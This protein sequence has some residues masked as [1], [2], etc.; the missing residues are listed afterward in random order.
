MCHKV[1]TLSQ[2]HDVSKWGGLCDTVKKTLWHCQNG[3]M[4]VSQRSLTLLFDVISG[5]L[6]IVF[7]AN[8]KKRV[9]KIF[10]SIYTKQHIFESTKRGG[11]ACN[12]SFGTK[13]G[14]LRLLCT[15][16]HRKCQ[17]VVHNSFLFE[18]TSVRNYLYLEETQ[19]HIFCSVRRRSSTFFHSVGSIWPS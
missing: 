15:Q 16:P 12:G 6:N 14:L 3:F 2:S 1:L 8:I 18:N 19:K 7:I 11:N 9:G 4:T 17:S 5:A 13:Q 10:S